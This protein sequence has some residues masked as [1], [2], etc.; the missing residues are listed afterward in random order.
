VPNR[1]V[2]I[3]RNFRGTSVPSTYADVVLDVLQRE[4]GG[5]PNAAKRLARAAR[6]S[7][8]TAENWLAK[9]NAPSGEALI[10]LMVECETLAD[11]IQE[12]IAERRAAKQDR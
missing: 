11:E 9:L 5:Q 6:T 4:Y 2:A 10:N 8:R 1:S 7:Y 3:T 12:L